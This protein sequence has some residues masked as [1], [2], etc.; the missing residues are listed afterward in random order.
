MVL[1]PRD[2]SGWWKPSARLSCS[3]SWAQPP[4]AWQDYS[5]RMQNTRSHF[6]QDQSSSGE[7]LNRHWLSPGLACLA[8]YSIELLPRLDVRLYERKGWPCAAQPWWFAEDLIDDM[9]K[10][11][12]NESLADCGKVGLAPFCKANPAP[13]VSHLYA[14]ITLSFRCFTHIYTSAK[15]HRRVINFGRSNMTMKPPKSQEGEENRQ[16]RGCQEEG[17][18]SHRL[19]P[20]SACRFFWVGGSPWLSWLLF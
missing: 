10:S 20:A 13:K 4:S 6:S 7:R 18:E 12:L 15:S 11:L 17:Q 3:S 1:L 5:R 16:E 8:G 14:I 9:T 19:W 2:L